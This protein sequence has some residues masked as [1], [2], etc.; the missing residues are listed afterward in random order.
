MHMILTGDPIDAPTALRYGLVQRVVPRKRLYREAE[1]LARTLMSRGPLALRLAKRAVLEGLDLPLA[2][3]LA[4]ERRLAHRALASADA[5]E[6]IAA[7][8]SRGQPR[9]SGA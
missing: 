1:S 6:G 7:P 4:L 5:Q 2:Q 3:G 9:F 8:T